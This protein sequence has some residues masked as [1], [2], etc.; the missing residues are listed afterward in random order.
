MS[1]SE[2]SVRLVPLVMASLGHTHTHTRARFPAT[3]PVRSPQDYARNEPKI[4]HTTHGGGGTNRRRA[5]YSNFFILLGIQ[6][7]RHT[8]THVQNTSQRNRADLQQSSA[9]KRSQTAC[10]AW[11]RRSWANDTQISCSPVGPGT[12]YTRTPQPMHSSHSPH[13]QTHSP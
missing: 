6:T 5:F 13:P 9:S 4:G 12:R 8:H 7:H 3:G 11:R 1:V 2:P 10:F